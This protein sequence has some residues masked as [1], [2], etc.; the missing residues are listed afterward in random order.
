MNMAAISGQLETVSQVVAELGMPI[1]ADFLD[2]KCDELQV[3]AVD[4]IFRA[5]ATRALAAAVSATG[6]QVGELGANEVAEGLTR[7]AVADGV[8]LRSQEL[9]EAGAELTAQGVVEM[10]AASGLRE[11]AQD[12]AAEGVGQMMEGSAEIGAAA[13]LGDVAEAIE[14]AADDE[15]Q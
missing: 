9:A 8:A 12:L 3:M 6:A 7:L 11:A 4:T 10:A 2:T 14:E 5:G 13:A 15:E 1:L